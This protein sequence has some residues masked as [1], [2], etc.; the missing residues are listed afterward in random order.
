MISRRPVSALCFFLTLLAFIILQRPSL[1][2][3]QGVI[4]YCAS[5]PCQAVVYFSNSFDTRLPL[6]L[7]IETRPIASEFNEYLIGRFDFKGNEYYPAG[8]PGFRTVTE[9]EAG[10]RDLENQMRQA[11]KK[12]VEVDWSYTPNPA[13]IARHSMNRTEHDANVPPGPPPT[14][15]FCLSDS[16][17]GTFYSTGPF[18]AGGNSTYANGGHYARRSKIRPGK[19]D[20]P[21]IS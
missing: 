4:S 3:A 10:K 20:P 19:S 17:Q 7:A 14:H 1:A 16:Y 21:C 6:P 2:N 5:D 11:S 8:C 15:T 9:A 18:A 12:V 13:E